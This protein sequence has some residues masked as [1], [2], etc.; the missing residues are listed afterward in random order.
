[1]ERIRTNG[2]RRALLTFGNGRSLRLAAW[3]RRAS[4]SCIPTGTRRFLK[5]LLSRMVSTASSRSTSSNARRCASPKRRLH[6]NEGA[7]RDLLEAIA[8]AQDV[9]IE[10]LLPFE[11]RPLR[12][13]YTDGFCGGAVIP[14]GEMEWPASD[15]HVPLA[16]QPALAGVLLAAAGARMGLDGNASSVVTQYDVLK[17]QKEF[18]MF[19]AAKPAMKRCI[20]QDTN[21]R[22][23]YRKK[24][25]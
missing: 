5:N 23:V 21:Y 12:I 14:L 22:Y 19:P 10:K 1:M 6:R 7:P 9:Q 25:R 8:L 3:Y 20:C 13:L 18:H 4:A 24:H 11:G 17:L 15:V 16:H 2:K